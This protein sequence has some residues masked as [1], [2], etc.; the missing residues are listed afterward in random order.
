MVQ[1]K[2]FWTKQ[3]DKRA[4]SEGWTIFDADG[5]LQIQRIDEPEDGDATLVIDAQAYQLCTKMALQGS[6]MH[7]LALYLDG[8]IN[9]EE[10]CV[11]K[12]ML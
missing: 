6:K 9:D 8:R 2:T 5:T 12:A 7:L 3:H 11:P 1:K 4:K 10:M